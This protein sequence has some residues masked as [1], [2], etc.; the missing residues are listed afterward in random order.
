MTK[1]PLNLTDDASRAIWANAQ[2][3]AERVKKWP[4]WKRGAAFL[5]RLTCC[6]RDNGVYGPATWSEADEFRESYLSGQGVRIGTSDPFQT[7]HDRSAIIVAAGGA[8]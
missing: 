4:A 2:R 6:G 7:G 5:V 1:I 3:V 8:G